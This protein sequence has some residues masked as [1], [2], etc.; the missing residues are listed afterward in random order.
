MKKIYTLMSIISIPFILLLYSYHTGSPGGKTGS[1][2]DN[3]NCTQCHAG[4]TN[5]IDNW[6]TSDIPAEGFTP[7][8]TY[9]I[10]LNAM[11]QI[12]VKFGFE[13]TAEDS[14]SKVGTFTLLDTERT[15][16]KNTTNSVTHTADGIDPIGH[17]IEWSFEW[18]APETSPD[19]VTFYAAVNA[20]NGNG[21]NTGD[22]IYLTSKS[23]NQFFV[24]IADNLLKDQVKL[25]PNPAN[26][27]VNVNLPANSELRIINITGQEVAYQKNTSS[28]EK[29][30]LSNLSDG[31][32][33][34]QV[35]HEADMAT[36][37][38]VKN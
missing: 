31:V 32:Y 8:E 24:G 18:T 14:E 4:E 25:Y 17:E 38:L 12:A 13:L 29:L 27:Y 15:Q 26:S 23:Y 9:V 21:Q 3:A 22:K 33:F 5:P 36:I 7:G 35:I 28:S 20:A 10:T 1:P 16:L 37:K 34:V 6:I 2:L 30:D 11:D 19:E